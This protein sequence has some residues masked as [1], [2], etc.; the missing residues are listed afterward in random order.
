MT[1]MSHQWANLS[2]NEQGGYVRLVKKKKDIVKPVMGKID[3]PN[4]FWPPYTTQ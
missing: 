3:I 4:Y 2:P 1:N